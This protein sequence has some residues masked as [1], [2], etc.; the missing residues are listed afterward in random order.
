MAPITD[1]M[2]YSSD[3]CTYGFPRSTMRGQ[4]WFITALT[5]R[6]VNV[7]TETESKQRTWR[8]RES[9]R[10]VQKEAWHH[11]THTHRCR[12]GL[13]PGAARTP[14][15]R[16]PCT[17]ARRY[18]RACTSLRAA[19]CPAPAR[20]RRRHLQAGRNGRSAVAH[21]HTSD[22]GDR[23]GDS[24]PAAA[25]EAEHLRGGAPARRRV[26]R[27]AARDACARQTTHACPAGLPTPTFAG[28]RPGHPTPD[29]IRLPGL[30]R[31]RARGKARG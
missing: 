8:W 26:G 24:L 29:T 6:S 16:R 5:T 21:S 7:P 13:R 14:S 28:A 1:R 17:W 20:W 3:F 12:A 9:D 30:Q 23:Q 2:W 18:P 31:G 15:C 19:S 4:Y 22:R 25:A 10:D 27:P 11:H